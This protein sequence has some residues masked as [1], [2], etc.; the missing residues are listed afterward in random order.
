MGVLN[1][2]GVEGKIP[3]IDISGL[4]SSSWIY[5]LII[6][7]CGFILIMGV[8]VFLFFITYKKKVVFFEN[9][10]G[11]GYQP[12]LKTRARIVKLGVGGEELLKT[13]KGGMFLTASGKKMGKNTYWFAKGQDGYH[14]NILVGDLDAKMGMLDIEPVDRDVR[15]FHVALDRLSH[16]TY[17]KTGFMEKY[18]VHMMLFLFLIVL[19]LGMWFIVGKI[20]DAVAPLG[21]STDVALKIQETNLELTSKLESIV[22]ILRNGNDGG[23]A[24]GLAPA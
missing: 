9:I 20:G 16:Q 12:V 13:L 2:L 22:N 1:E 7:L 17:G 18:G 23:A 5:V 10:S 24:G 19:V 4:A 11:Q 3:T 21:A 6:A 15:M 14:Y 8:L